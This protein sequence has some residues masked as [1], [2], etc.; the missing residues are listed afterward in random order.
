M[1]GKCEIAAESGLSR[2][3]I[4][5]HIK[6]YHDTVLEQEEQFKLLKGNM[7]SELC[8]MAIRGG[9]NVNA[10]KLF[11]EATELLAITKR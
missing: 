10:V 3:T 7:L 2:Q 4:H 9:G 1:P 5:N 6:N 11:L 8:G